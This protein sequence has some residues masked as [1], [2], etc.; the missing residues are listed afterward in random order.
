MQISIVA[1]KLLSFDPLGLI[2][3]KQLRPQSCAAIPRRASIGLQIVLERETNKSPEPRPVVSDD[4]L[5]RKT[6]TRF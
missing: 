4:R 1:L 2:R 3:E 6:F 5:A